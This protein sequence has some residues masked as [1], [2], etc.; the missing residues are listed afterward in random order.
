MIDK[1][2][3]L[4][5]HELRRLLLTPDGKGSQVKEAALKEIIERSTDKMYDTLRESLSGQL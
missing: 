2:S 4:S 3:T 1:I 5:D